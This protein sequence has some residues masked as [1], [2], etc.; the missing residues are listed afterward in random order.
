[1]RVVPPVDAT[2]PVDTSPLAPPVV[3]PPLPPFVAPPV[4]PA[5]VPPVVAPPLPDALVPAVAPPEASPLESYA[6][7]TSRQP[8]ETTPHS[9]SPAP[10]IAP[11]SIHH[12]ARAR[13]G[14]SPAR[15]GAPGLALTR[16]ETR[17]VWGTGHEQQAQGHHPPLGYEAT[18]AAPYHGL[19]KLREPPLIRRSC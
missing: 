12:R 13:T 1:M 6:G 5:V 2:A 15:V 7:L 3:P 19:G 14:S 8:V 17:C 4:P 9:V 16:R 11:A 18:S 10:R